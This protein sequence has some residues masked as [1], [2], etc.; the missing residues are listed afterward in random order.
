MKTLTISGYDAASDTLRDQRLAQ[1]LYDEGAVIM[2]DVLLVLHGADHRA[3]RLLELRVFRRDFFRFYEH[4]VFPA[5]LKQTI[6]P[7]EAAGRADLMELSYRLTMNLT[8][9]FAG[10]DRPRRNA[11]ETE[12]LRRQVMVF[13]EGATLV[14]STRDKDSVRA[15]VRAALVEFN[16][17]FYQPSL[18]RRQQLLADFAAGR[19]TEEALPRD[20]LTVLLQNDERVEMPPDL[21]MREIAFYLQAGSH[22]TANA[23]A[24]AFH[25][26]MTWCINHPEDQRRID[27]DPLF[28]QRCVHESLRLHPASPVAWRRSTCPMALPNGSEADT[29]DRVV[30]DLATANRDPTIFGHDAD[31][32]NPHRT[33]REGTPP[34]G[35]TFGVGVHTCLGRDLDGGLQ[36]RE[37]ADPDTHQYGIVPL[38]VQELVRR[39][40]RPDPADKALAASH[41]ERANW[42]YYPILLDPV[43]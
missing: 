36:P 29:N 21:M 12:R 4:E 31:V 9:D 15:E 3:R 23:T 13:S 6:A 22:S 18:E 24:H 35:L 43:R 42:G 20:V 17:S 26:V 27:A 25:D 11:E 14:H 1:S 30:V 39:K 28:L 5:T 10:V 19:I 8:A 2:A 38:L 32:F 34:W 33:V 7:Y 16:T 41:T 40:A 37:D